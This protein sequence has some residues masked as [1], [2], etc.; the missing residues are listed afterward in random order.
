MRSKVE[1]RP[2]D[3][4]E[5]Q[6]FAVVSEENLH[7]SGN[8]MRLKFDLFVFCFEWLSAQGTRLH[9]ATGAVT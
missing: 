2:H 8:H 3:A 5:I 9:K 4:A 7:I 6:L 1:K